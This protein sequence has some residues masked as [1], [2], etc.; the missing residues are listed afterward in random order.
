MRYGDRSIMLRYKD[1]CKAQIWAFQLRVGMGLIQPFY[2]GKFLGKRESSFS[3]F[4][5]PSL[6]TIY[7]A[8]SFYFAV[9]GSPQFILGYQN[10]RRIAYDTQSDDVASTL[11]FLDSY[12]VTNNTDCRLTWWNYHTYSLKTQN[13]TAFPVCSFIKKAE[14]SYNS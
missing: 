14:G 8:P 7:T 5:F 11:G 2:F 1:Q 3:A 10:S 4:F 12:A 13:P 6:P 9:S